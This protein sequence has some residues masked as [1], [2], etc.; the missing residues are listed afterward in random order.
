VFPVPFECN[1]VLLPDDL[2]KCLSAVN[3]GTDKLKLRGARL[4]KLRFVNGVL[5]L[6]PDQAPSISYIIRRGCAGC[7]D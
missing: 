6:V 1:E 7:P 3:E 2:G 5:Q 4:V